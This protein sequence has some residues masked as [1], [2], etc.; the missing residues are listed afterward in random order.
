MNMENKKNI[1]STPTP[2]MGWNSWDCFGV[3]VTEQEVKEN[4]LY[5]AQHLKQYGWEYIVVDLDWYA[6][7]ATIANYK[8]PNIELITDQYGRLTPDP[9]RFPSSANGAGFK[10]LA[11]FV[12]SLGLKFGIHIMRGMP[13]CAAEQNLPIKGSDMKCSDIADKSDM[14]LWY[15]SMYGINCTKKGAQEYYNSIVELYNSWDVDFIKADDMG[16]WDGD[17]L[18]SPYRT[19]EVE[20]LT[21]AVNNGGRQTVLSL[22]PG[23]AYVGNAAHLSRNATMWRISYDFWDSWEALLRQFPRC[24]AWA[25]R[26]VFGHWPDCDMLPLGRISIRGDV[27]EARYTNF[28][29]PEQYTLMTLWAIFQS[30]LMF[31]GHLPESDPLSLKLITNADVIYVNQFGVNPT[32]VLRT[33]DQIVWVSED[34][35]SQ[36]KFV[37]MFNISDNAK[38]VSYDMGEDFRSVKELWS[39]EVTKSIEAE[40][41]AHG[42]KIFRITR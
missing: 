32:Q 13:W 14:C 11:D 26:K 34:S 16:T 12:H 29:E 36:D 1:F 21:A 24:E 10:P 19:D 30:P 37:A 15:R 28:N 22:S 40:I 38:V 27:G 25:S 8:T 41:D 9:V 31:G 33:E 17:G 18:N 5:V 23:A 42:A 2:P 4:A 6:P 3:N 39:G 35:K 20:M 7:Q